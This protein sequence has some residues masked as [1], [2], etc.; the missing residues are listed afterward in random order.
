MIRDIKAFKPED[1]AKYADLAAAA[2]STDA[3]RAT[4]GTKS[5][6]E[7]N[8]DLYDYINYNMMDDAATAVEETAGEIMDEIA[9][10]SG[11]EIAEML[12]TMDENDL[13]SL[14]SY[15]MNYFTDPNT[16]KVDYDQ[17]FKMIGGF[18]ESGWTAEMAE[19]AEVKLEDAD[20]MREEAAAVAEDEAETVSDDDL[21]AL[22]WDSV[23]TSLD[24]ENLMGWVQSMQTGVTEGYEKA[25]ESSE[26][27]SNLLE[28]IFGAFIGSAAE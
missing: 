8:A 1:I 6:I 28:G 10:L 24:E 3:G 21:W 17:V 2:G 23:F 14:V 18:L 5:M 9:D 12:S 4:A 19:A 16:G 25:L 15:V 27:L 20:K 11:E 22:V 26:E 13:N 7:A